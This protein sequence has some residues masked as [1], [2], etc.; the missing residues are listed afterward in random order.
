M[1]LSIYSS[2]FS[3]SELGV[4][5]CSLCPPPISLPILLHFTDQPSCHNHTLTTVQTLPYHNKKIPDPQPPIS[6]SQQFSFCIPLPHAPKQTSVYP[7]HSFM[8]YPSSLLSPPCIVSPTP[9]PLIR[10]RNIIT[11][12]PPSPTTTETKS[13]STNTLHRSSH[14]LHPPSSNP[15]IQLRIATHFSRVSTSTPSP[16][17][18]QP[19]PHYNILA[20]RRVK[21]V[22]L[23]ITQGIVSISHHPPSAIYR[24]RPLSIVQYNTI[25][26]QF[27][28]HL[29]SHSMQPYFHH[30][31]KQP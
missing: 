29:R 8:L 17:T 1:T 19:H 28:I 6:R 18:Y 25:P 14:Q 21:P 30:A 23:S 31:T 26:L 7:P 27:R 16:Q 11:Q 4:V 20:S 9:H 15:R 24:Q 12:L 13:Q 2:R 3:I 10:D 5:R 22:T